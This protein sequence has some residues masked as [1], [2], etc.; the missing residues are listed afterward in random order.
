LHRSLDG[1]A[2]GAFLCRVVACT[3]RHVGLDR[4]ERS[5]GEPLTF[6]ILGFVHHEGI[7]E[8]NLENIYGELGDCES[9]WNKWAHVSIDKRWV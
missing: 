6:G 4:V 5:G 3:G 9:R 2:H 7:V 1:F 8:K